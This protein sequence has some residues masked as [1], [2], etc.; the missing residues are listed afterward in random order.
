VDTQR[1]R[2]VF[3]SSIAGLRRLNALGYGAPGTGLTLDL[4]YNPGGPSLPP[5][6]TALEAD[7]REVLDRDFGIRF[8]RL[9]T[10]VNIPIGRFG[11]TLLSRDEL[12]DYL[13]LLKAA[14]QSVNTESVMCRGLISVDWKGWLYDCDFN[15]MLGLPLGAGDGDGTGGG[16]THLRDLSTLMLGGRLE[17]GQIQ[18]ADHCYGCTAGQ[19]SSCGG[20]LN[21]GPL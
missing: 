10:L 12:G 4:V 11:S 19:G 18:V 7:Y 21:P 3:E 16:R 5:P 8:N 9:L 20:A 1:G 14:H 2:G 6:Q 15:Q 17:D 13:G